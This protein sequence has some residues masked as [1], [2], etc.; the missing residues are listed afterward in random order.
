MCLFY[1]YIPLGSF[2]ILYCCSIYEFCW[3]VGMRLCLFSPLFGRSVVTCTF[4]LWWWNK[5]KEFQTYTM[6]LRH[7]TNI[8]LRVMHFLKYS[9]RNINWSCFRRHVKRGKRLLLSSRELIS[10]TDQ[11]PP[12][13]P[14]SISVVRETDNSSRQRTHFRYTVDFKYTPDNK[15][16]ATQ[17]SWKECMAFCAV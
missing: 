14:K 16:C 11:I 12:P 1:R 7:N 8:V 2:R 13:P 5:I 3:L 4:W 6:T 15:Q 17:H 9:T 10:I